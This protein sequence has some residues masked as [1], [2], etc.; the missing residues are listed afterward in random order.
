MRKLLGR[1]DAILLV[2]GKL[3]L[4]AKIVWVDAWALERRLDEVAAAIAAAGGREIPVEIAGS[5]F[6]LYRG[7]FLEGAGEA[8]WMLGMRQRLRGKFMRNLVAVGK[9]FEDQGEADRA[10]RLYERGLELDN[11]S[12]ELY[13]RSISP[14]QKMVKSAAALEAYRRCRH[15]LS[16]VLGVKPSAETEAIYRSLMAG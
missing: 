3:T 7:H 6:A 11:L 1:D 10:I 13:R 15:L 4:N 9:R 12:E 8:A 5:I 14:H 16:V 2:D